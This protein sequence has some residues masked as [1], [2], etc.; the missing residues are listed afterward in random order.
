LK[1]TVITLSGNIGAGK[2]TLGAHIASHY[3]AKWL[4][5]SA[6]SSQFLHLIAD[7]RGPSRMVAQMAF[8]AMRVA[9]LYSEIIKGD[10]P[11]IVVERGL[12]DSIAFGHVW[13]AMFGLQ[14][15]RQFFE[16]F[17]ALLRSCDPGGYDEH[18]VWLSCPIA[19][20]EA[21]L[22]R[23]GLAS[24]SAHTHEV[25]MRLEDEYNGMFGT[26]HPSGLHVHK[27]SSDL[28]ALTTATVAEF[29]STV[30]SSLDIGGN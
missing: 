15:H 10:I 12:R 21:R 17:Y 11:I 16:E 6:F 18:V 23:R 26:E 19:T 24:E 5:E 30:A 2:T 4:A 20:L 25:L 3:Q 22:S 27:V 7:N 8:S 9:T 13:E 14:G 28:P 29:V 1:P